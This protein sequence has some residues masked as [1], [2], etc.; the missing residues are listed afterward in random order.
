ME[1]SKHAKFQAI[2]LYNVMYNRIANL[3]YVIVWQKQKKL[4]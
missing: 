1:M 4:L 3:L 2:P